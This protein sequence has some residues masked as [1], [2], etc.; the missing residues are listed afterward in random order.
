MQSDGELN[1]SAEPV[2]LPDPSD[3]GDSY[4]QARTLWAFGEGYAAFERED[5]EFAAFLRDRI[6]LSVGRWT[7]T[8]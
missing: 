4:W 6:R 3:S 1:P 7:A 2:E 5:P 8:C